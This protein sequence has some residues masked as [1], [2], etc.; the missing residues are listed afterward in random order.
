MHKWFACYIVYSFIYLLNIVTEIVAIYNK[1]LR[2]EVPAG[3]LIAQLVSML[4]CLKLTNR[5]IIT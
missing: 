1:L 2:V 5:M 4:K 3:Y